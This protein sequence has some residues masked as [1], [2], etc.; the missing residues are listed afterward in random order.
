MHPLLEK[1]PIFNLQFAMRTQ[2]AHGGHSSVG[3][4]SDCGSECRGFEPHSPPPDILRDVFFFCI[5]ACTLRYVLSVIPSVSVSKLPVRP[6][7]PI[8]PNGLALYKKSGGGEG[9]LGQ[10]LARCTRCDLRSALCEP[11]I[12][13]KPL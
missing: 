2:F 7:Y 10:V 11:H 6:H 12:P 8:N 3:R 1:C 5:A 9:S 4:A 13:P